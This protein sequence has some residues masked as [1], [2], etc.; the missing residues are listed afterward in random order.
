MLKRVAGL[1]MG[2]F[3][4]RLRSEAVLSSGG[5]EG[6]G[7]GSTSCI[8]FLWATTAQSLLPTTFTHI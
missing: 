1:V 3:V 5:Q 7:P 8:A 4:Q 6:C 2:D